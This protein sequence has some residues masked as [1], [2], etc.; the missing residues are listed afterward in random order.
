MGV[1][2]TRLSALE[3]Q[4][5]SMIPPGEEPVTFVFEDGERLTFPNGHKALIFAIKNR[6]SEKMQSVTIETKHQNKASLAK[7]VIA[8]DHRQTKGE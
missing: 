5:L 7:A 4:F 3:K 2:K 6:N 8:G 1:I